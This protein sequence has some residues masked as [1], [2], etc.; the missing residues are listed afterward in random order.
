MREILPIFSAG[1]LGLLFGLGLVTSHMTDPKRITD[2]LDFTGNW[3]PSL[4]FVMIGAIVVTAPA[5]VIA[6]G[7]K[8]AF[9]GDPISLPDRLKIDRPLAL[10]SAIFGVGW[11]LAGICPGPGIT[12]L[13]ALDKGAM[14]FVPAVIAGMFVSWFVL[15]PLVTR[16]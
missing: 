15:T 7:R 2:F 1:L 12:L 16:N 11:G 8:K 13:G 5:F 14:V 3:D 9:L 10:G 6:R 4:A